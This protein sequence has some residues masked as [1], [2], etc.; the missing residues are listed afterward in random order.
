MISITEEITV[1]SPPTRVWEVISDPSAVVSCIGG[2]ELGA[3]HEDGSFD[4]TLAIRF[5]GLR[6]KF[7]ARVALDLD[8]SA[9]EGRLTARGGDGQGATR[10]SA[11]ATFRV[12]EGDTLGTS[13][14]Y[15]DGEIKLNGKL[16][17]LIE[18][19]AGVVVTR[20]TKEFTDELVK[21]CAAPAEPGTA[22]VPKLLTAV[23]AGPSAADS[24]EPSAAT[25]ARPRPTAPTGLFARLRAWW[26]GRKS[27]RQGLSPQPAHHS[28]DNTSDALGQGGRR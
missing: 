6:V 11:G 25:A 15:C 24:A 1:P 5:G 10:F 23:P 7:A 28:A 21:A 13:R 17:K 3:S 2:A 16:A 26:A 4:G 27:R 12:T 18:S 20:M 22:A 14:V 8:E 9:L 19:G